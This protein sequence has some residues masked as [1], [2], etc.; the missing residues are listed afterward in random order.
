[1][2][3]AIDE[4]LL[5]WMRKNLFQEYKILELGSGAGTLELKKQWDVTSIEH[6]PDFLDII[7]HDY[8]YAPLKSHKEIKNYPSENLWYDREIL[9]EKLPKLS[10]QVLLI[11]GP[12]CPNR[13]GLIKYWDL[14]DP[15]AMW[16]F[17]DLH[18]RQEQKLI[19]GISNRLQ[20]EYTV[21]NAWGKGKPFGVIR[22]K[23]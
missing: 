15:I 20:R 2:S 11:D 12:P 6:N 13:V 21:Y 8:I 16:I 18:R 3:W 7:G 19:H 4:D 14:F 22:R 17:D 23:E 9:K 1:M 10:Y 5:I